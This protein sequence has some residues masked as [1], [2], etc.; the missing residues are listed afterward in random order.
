MHPTALFFDH[1]TALADV[2]FFDEIAEDEERRVAAVP[3]ALVWTP[4]VFC[5]ASTMLHDFSISAI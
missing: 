2:V 1:G 4:P 3:A 5:R